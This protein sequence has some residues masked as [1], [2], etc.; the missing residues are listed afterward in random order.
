MQEHWLGA[1]IL[2]RRE[3]EL[4]SRI[5]A[6]TIL[7]NQR[8]ASL[9]ITYEELVH[10]CVDSW[11]VIAIYLCKESWSSFIN[12]VYPIKGDALFFLDVASF[13]SCRL[14]T[15]KKPAMLQVANLTGQSLQN[16]TSRHQHKLSF[17][18]TQ[19]QSFDSNPLYHRLEKRGP[20][21]PEHGK[22]RW[23]CRSLQPAKNFS[24]PLLSSHKHFGKP[25]LLETVSAKYKTLR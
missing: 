23:S 11:M 7:T 9:M 13:W 21:A 12:W 2:V 24:Q 18:V 4:D 10:V 15:Y 25:R 5:G 14:K 19:C 17:F 1:P 16:S 22:P 3:C 20:R 6:H 8:V